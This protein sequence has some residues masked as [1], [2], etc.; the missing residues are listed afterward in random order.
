MVVIDRKRMQEIVIGKAGDVLT[1]PIVVTLIESRKTRSK[2][3]V[4][5]QRDV[6]ITRGVVEIPA[7][8]LGAD[9]IETAVAEAAQICG[10]RLTN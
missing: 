1:G 4:H 7:I 10:P 3:G 8:E 5:A 9:D 2:I 6:G